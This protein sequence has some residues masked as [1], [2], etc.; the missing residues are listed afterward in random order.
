MQLYTV[1]L[2][3]QTDS[4]WRQLTTAANDEKHA[5]KIA[6]DREAELVGY[7]LTDRKPVQQI[8]YRNH[9]DGVHATVNMDA[10]AGSG[11]AGH[12]LLESIQRDHAVDGDGKAYGPNNRL[13]A[14][15]HAHYQREPYKVASVERNEPNTQQIIQALKQLQGNPAAWDRML[16]RLKDEGVPL[17]VVTGSLYGLTAQKMIDGSTP[18]VWTTATIKCGLTTSTYTPNQDTHHFWSDITNEVSGTG[19]TAGGTTLTTTGGTSY[20]TASD[21]IRLDA[22]DA[23]WTTS[24]ITARDAIVWNDTA[25][26]STTDPVIGWVNFGADVST[27]AGTFSIVWDATGIVVYDVT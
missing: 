14:H 10:F 20:D 21:Q 16:E 22:T 12:D 2:E 17:G 4:Q 6:Q 15:L 27:T 19:Y 24:T 3:S 18:I 13:K 25:G 5:A 1:R 23:S 8:A 26:A 9:P 7:S 11:L